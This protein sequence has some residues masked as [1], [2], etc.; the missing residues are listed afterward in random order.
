MTSPWPVWASSFKLI[1]A[2]LLLRSSQQNIHMILVLYRT[3]FRL[4]DHSNSHLLLLSIEQNIHT[5]LVLSIL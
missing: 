4:V 5:I 2:H 3:V 1:I